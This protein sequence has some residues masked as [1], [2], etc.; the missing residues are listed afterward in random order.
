MPSEPTRP[1]ESNYPTVPV[2]S[3]TV[4]P[5]PSLADVR[6]ALQDQKE[7]EVPEVIV[8]AD[9]ATGDLNV[10]VTMKLG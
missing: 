6:Q 3:R 10:Q 8:T 5:G 4:D 1:A 7:V 2:L 9:P